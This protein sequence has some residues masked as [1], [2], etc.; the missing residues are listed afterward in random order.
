ML[1]GGDAP[2]GPRLPDRTAYVK[3]SEVFDDGRKADVAP[4]LRGEC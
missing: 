1:R 3:V 4:L 2:H